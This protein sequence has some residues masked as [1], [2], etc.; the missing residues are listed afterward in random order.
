MSI[1]LL[2]K[3][4]CKLDCCTDVIKSSPDLLERRYINC[5]IVPT[6][7]NGVNLDGYVF[8]RQ[9]VSDN[10][11]IR[12]DGSVIYPVNNSLGVKICYMLSRTIYP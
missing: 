5:K 4:H 11:K 2:W 10:S 6:G 7:L 1:H 12:V 9:L 3:V 8:F